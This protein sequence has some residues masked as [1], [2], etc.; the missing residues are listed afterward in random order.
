MSS[1]IVGLY[2]DYDTAEQVVEELLN[3]E[4]PA[5]NIC[6]VVN[7]E[8]DEEEFYV[9]QAQLVGEEDFEL[10]GVDTYVEEGDAV[11]A[12]VRDLMD[13]LAEM[14]LAADEAEYYAEEVR[15]GRTMIAVNSPA[16]KIDRVKLIINQYFPVDTRE[17]RLNEQGVAW[18]FFS[19]NGNGAEG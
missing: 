3:N 12:E 9:I 5:P 19:T 18:N 16:D 6:M 4:I 17:R 13:I 14:G 15:Q 7:D 10:D 1:T 11:E 2:D 8:E